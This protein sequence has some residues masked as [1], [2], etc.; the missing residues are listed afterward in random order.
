MFDLFCR[1]K[2]EFLEPKTIFAFAQ[3]G[4]YAHFQRQSRACILNYHPHDC[5]CSDCRSLWLFIFC[6]FLSFSLSFRLSVPT[7]VNYCA[8][9]RIC[10][11]VRAIAI[12]SAVGG[13]HNSTAA[14]RAAFYAHVNTNM[15]VYVCKTVRNVS[16]TRPRRRRQSPT[17]PPTQSQYVRPDGCSHDITHNIACKYLACQSMCC[18]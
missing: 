9:F 7:F 18:P 5:Q 2:A 10:L 12:E 1:K 14:H 6:F 4:L 3:T 8:R 15:L 13:A 16:N 11:C 17:P